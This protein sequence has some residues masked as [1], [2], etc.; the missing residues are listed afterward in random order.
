MTHP[1]H[2][3]RSRLPIPRPEKCC[4]GTKVMVRPRNFTDCH[5]R[6]PTCWT[7][8]LA[9]GASVSS[10]A[11]TGAPTARSVG[12][13][14]WSQWSWETRHRSTWGSSS[15]RSAGGTLRPTTPAGPIRS[16]ST[17][18]RRSETPSSCTRKLACPSQVM[19][20]PSPFAG[21]VRSRSRSGT[22]VGM[23]AR[24]GVERLDPSSR[25]RICQRSSPPN[26][27]VSRGSRFRK[28]PSSS[29]GWAGGVAAWAAIRRAARRFIPVRG[30]AGS[31]RGASRRGARPAPVRPGGRVAPRCG[32]S[33]ALRAPGG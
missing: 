23:G 28:R 19:R 21:G 33:R 14:M 22:T 24:S 17:G 8:S 16:P 27:W 15:G 10:P 2:S 29:R 31:C 12:T 30:A 3:V 5:Q 11:S 9:S 7:F 13:S 25:S 4:A 1:P 26:P 18:S 32:C 6:S 20:A